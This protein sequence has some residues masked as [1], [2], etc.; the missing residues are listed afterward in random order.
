[1]L[2]D[3]ERIQLFD[4]CREKARVKRKKKRD[5]RQMLM[6]EIYEIDISDEEIMRCMA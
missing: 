6:K 1:M 2:S 3:E 4:S 5:E